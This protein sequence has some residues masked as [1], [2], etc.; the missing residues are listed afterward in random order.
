MVLVLLSLICNHD[1]FDTKIALEKVATLM[2]GG[3][4]WVDSKL[5]VYQKW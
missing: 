1:T 3:F 5:E 4:L 2:K